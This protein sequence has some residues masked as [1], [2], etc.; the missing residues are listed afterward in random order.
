MRLLHRI[1]Y[2]LSRLSPK[3]ALFPRLYV[4][5]SIPGEIARRFSIVVQVDRIIEYRLSLWKCSQI[6]RRISI[7][8][9]MEW[10]K[11]GTKKNISAI[12]LKKEK[13]KK[14]IPPPFSSTRHIL[15][16]LDKI[17]NKNIPMCASHSSSATDLIYFF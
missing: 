8:V 3:Y 14:F 4:S 15:Q 12:L 1:K 9:T 17:F 11:R 7:L 16:L 6:F 13:N 2:E 5:I 10:I